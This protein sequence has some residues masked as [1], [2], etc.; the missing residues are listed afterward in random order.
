MHDAANRWQMI[1]DDPNTPKVLA[2]RRSL[3][4][5]ARAAS[6]IEDRS[7]YLCSLVH[8]KSILDIGIVDHT[9]GA[10]NRPEWLH[11]KLRAS[12]AR[13]L[14]VDILESEIGELSRRGYDVLVADIATSPLQ[15][16]FD[17]IVGAEVLEHLDAPGRFMANCAA[18]LERR[19]RLVITTPNPWY[20]NAVLKSCFGR[21]IF[22][23][24]V[25][26]IAWY[27]PSAL[28][29][30]GER[31]GLRLD[32][33][34]GIAVHGA[35]GPLARLFFWLRPA[36]TK[37]GLAPEVFAKSILYEFVSN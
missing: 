23:D 35:T 17:V 37:A 6:L 29:E 16:T 27:E 30:L 3:I 11:G 8:R 20:A 32:R 22:V 4:A 28:V 18:M 1:S 5:K 10:M 31:N 7:E 12:A 19:G 21:S 36:L 15:R 26:H 2:W 24:S 9:P 25:D 33:F 13:C 34:G 14:G